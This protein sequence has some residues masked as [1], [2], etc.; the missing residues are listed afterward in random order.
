VTAYIDTSALL[1]IILQEPGALEELRTYDALISSELLA[2]ESR[3]TIDRL[4]LQ[5][6]LTAEEAA[7]YLAAVAQWL[8]AIDLVLLRAPVLSRAGEPLPTP[9][10]TLDAVHL[11][12]ALV[13]RDR[14]GPLS[15]VATHDA[16]LGLAA[17]SFGFE[18]R[19][20]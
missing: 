13:W 17:R 1:R 15:T 20:L 2:V 12:T 11:A 8:E 14:M 18:V 19:G 5:G 4:R 16:A 6:S 9:L 7:A 10:G 3:R